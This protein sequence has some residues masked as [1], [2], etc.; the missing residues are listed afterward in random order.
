MDVNHES[1]ERSGKLIR[2][3]GEE[4]GTDIAQNFMTLRS[5]D[6]HLGDPAS[7]EAARIFRKGQDGHPGYEAAVRDLEMAAKNM[8]KAYEAIGRAIV[9]MSE[10]VRTADWASMVDIGSVR[11]II[12]FGESPNDPISVPATQ[13]ETT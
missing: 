7:D 2:D 1:M 6:R 10:N 11:A 9:A 3:V 5:I 13:V 4:F 12:D 8:D